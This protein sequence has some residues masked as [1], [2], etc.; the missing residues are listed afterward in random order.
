MDGEPRGRVPREWW[1]R[2]PLQLTSG[3]RG[4][5]ARGG[6]RTAT[7]T[8][9][10]GSLCLEFPPRVKRVLHALGSGEDRG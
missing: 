7:H 2:Q 3:T 1:P 4:C 8:W 9:G 5:R 6:S 10:S